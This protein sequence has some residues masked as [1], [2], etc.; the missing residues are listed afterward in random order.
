M[1]ASPTVAVEDEKHKRCRPRVT[2]T[3]FSTYGRLRCQGRNALKALAAE[4]RWNSDELS[5]QRNQVAR[6]RKT[7]EQNLLHAQADVLLLSLGAEGCTGWQKHAR[8]PLNRQRT[9]AKT[10]EQVATIRTNRANAGARRE[11]LSAQNCQ[12]DQSQQKEAEEASETELEEQHEICDNDAWT[13]LNRLMHD[14]ELEDPFDHM[15]LDMDTTAWNR[16]S[17]QRQM[18]KHL[19][20]QHCKTQLPVSIPA[21]RG[22]MRG[23]RALVQLVLLMFPAAFTLPLTQS[24][25]LHRASKTFQVRSPPQPRSASP[26]TARFFVSSPAVAMPDELWASAEAGGAPDGAAEDDENPTYTAS[27]TMRSWSN[28]SSPLVG[29]KTA[30]GWKASRERRKGVLKLA[31]KRRIAGRSKP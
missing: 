31:T 22:R 26:G 5:T 29:Q 19:N 14:D 7:Q 15:L 9:A 16:R 6:W 17:P 27:P 1:T 21:S 2:P 10:S 12:S 30:A 25:L 23:R 11:V 4:A 8:T 28:S 13:E 24:G 3:A 18:R 20:L